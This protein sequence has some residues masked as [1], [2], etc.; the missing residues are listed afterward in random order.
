[1]WCMNEDTWVTIG[2]YQ[3]AGHEGTLY[4]KYG[5]SFHGTNINEWVDDFNISFDAISRFKTNKVNGHMSIHCGT[6]KNDEIIVKGLSYYPVDDLDDLNAAWDYLADCG[7]YVKL[8]CAEFKELLS[9]IGIGFNSTIRSKN[10]PYDIIPFDRYKFIKNYGFIRQMV[11]SRD[12][13]QCQCCKGESDLEVH[14][15]FSFKNN[16]ELGDNPN[17]MITLCRNCH[18]KYHELLGYNSNPV[19]LIN[20]IKKY[21]VELNECL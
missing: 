16:L 3:F 8:S 1:M 10:Y 20:F 6:L 17:N 13:N 4:V 18:E 21:G 19:D 12:N 15:C 14:H 7:L 5:R 11:L 2:N 9:F